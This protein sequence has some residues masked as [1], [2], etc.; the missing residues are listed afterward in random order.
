MQTLLACRAERSVDRDRTVFPCLQ[1][2]Q[3]P[4]AP[5]AVAVALGRIGRFLWVGG[6]WD[7]ISMN[8]WPSNETGPAEGAMTRRHRSTA[9]KLPFCSSLTCICGLFAGCGF[10]WW[11]GVVF[12][13]WSGRKLLCGCLIVWGGNVR[14][15]YVGYLFCEGVCDR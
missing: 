1:L 11:W 4:F 3:L 8:C 13:L 9:G 14:V 2:S 6:G 7:T 12:L 15:V 10:V 5:L